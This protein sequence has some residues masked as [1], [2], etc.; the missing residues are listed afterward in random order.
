MR[1]N[2]CTDC[3]SA[4]INPDR[5][6]KSIISGG[7][8]TARNDET[9]AR[10]IS[11]CLF[12]ATPVTGAFFD[13]LR[14]GRGIFDRD[15]G[16]PGMSQRLAGW[17]AAAPALSWLGTGGRRPAVLRSSALG[18]TAA[19]ALLRGCAGGRRKSMTKGI[20]GSH[21]TAGTFLRG[22]TGGSH[23]IMAMRF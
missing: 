17:P 18:N 7:L 13:S 15:P 19:E 2:V 4:A 11:C 3:L 10:S 20:A 9:I 21:T 16:A 12:N 14:H 1:F 6:G 22:R 23:P 8:K 5:A